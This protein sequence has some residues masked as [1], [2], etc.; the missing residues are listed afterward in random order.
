MLHDFLSALKNETNFHY[1]QVSV[2]IIYIETP[3]KLQIITINKE[4]RPAKIV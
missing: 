4:V 3:N 1:S 2:D